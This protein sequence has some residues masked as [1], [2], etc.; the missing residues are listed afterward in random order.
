M[1]SIVSHKGYALLFYFPIFCLVVSCFSKQPLML[2]EDI[3]RRKASQ[4]S[5]IEKYARQGAHRFSYTWES[6]AWQDW[7]DKGV[8]VD[9]TVAYL[10]QQKAMP[11]FKARKYEVGMG[12]LDKAVRY[13][14]ESYLPY[15]AF[16]NCIFVKNYTN[17]LADFEACKRL[18]GDQYEMDHTYSFYIG[19]SLL[20]LNRFEEAVAYFEQTVRDQ[21]NKFDEAHHLDL[22]YLAITKYELEQYDEAISVFDRVLKQYPTFSDA[23]YFKAHCL[24]QKGSPIGEIEQLVKDAKNYAL[25]G[26]TINEDNEVYEQYPYQVKWD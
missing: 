22:F 5:I 7:L 4:D 15:R 14:R 26:Y 8:A 19:L 11:Y 23:L 16:I 1:M 12:Y 21:E 2:S 9:S 24:F 13:D 18:W 25:Q 3:Q 6:K 17:A 10:W 20:Q